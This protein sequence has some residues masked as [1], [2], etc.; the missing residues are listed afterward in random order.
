MSTKTKLYETVSALMVPGKGL[1]AADESDPTAG[2]RLQMVHL[3]NE[4][5]NRRDFREL[6]LTAEGIEEY[7]SGVIL[8]D[9]TIRNT[10]SEGMPFPDVL[11][12]KGIVPG[13]KVDRG[14]T[15]LHNF[16]GEQVTRGLD[17]LAERFAE[18]YDMGARF[19]K[20]RA[21]F[22]IDEETPTD[23]CIE[24]N[25]IMLTRYAQFAQAAGL[26][27]IV[28]PEVLFPGDHDLIRS[29]QV[30]TRV[31]QILFSTLQKY[32]VDLEGLIL[33]TS[34]VMAGDGHKDATSPE[35]V[36]NATLRTFHLSVPYSVGGIVFL[37]GGQTPKRATEN[38]QAIQSLGEKPWPISFSY[39]RA[40]EE[41]V[42]TT[43]QGKEENIAEA[44]KVLLHTAKMNGLAQQ[45][46]YQAERDRKRS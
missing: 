38:L 6:L 12:A 21:V 9:S 11:L 28:E 40:I 30:N 2:K 33:K 10:T 3:P 39:S 7:L 1:L 24:M 26:V 16:K 42:L 19:S 31:L 23:A 43:W 29:E 13:I 15:D 4:P 5:D 27:P 14:L 25:A 35:E 36:A 8:Y 45:G 41:P 17:D 22:T 46:K 32:Q 20:W 34:M 18:Y 44:Q 37:S